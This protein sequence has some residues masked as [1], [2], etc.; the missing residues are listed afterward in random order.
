MNPTIHNSAP[1][2]ALPWP[3]WHTGMRE[4]DATPK[5]I[6]ALNDVELSQ[7]LEAQRAFLRAHRGIGGDPVISHEKLMGAY[8]LERRI[9]WRIVGRFQ[10]I[11][12]SQHR[13][14]T[15]TFFKEAA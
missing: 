11:V 1:V 12:E 2:L 10:A 5:W 7:T 15:A 6:Y 9:E 8:E 14:Y 3:A 4:S 13:G